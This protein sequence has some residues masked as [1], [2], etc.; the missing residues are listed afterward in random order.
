MALMHN[1]YNKCDKCK[2]TGAESVQRRGKEDFT[3][4]ILCVS[5]SVEKGSEALRF[6]F[7]N[8]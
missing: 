7:P 5:K 2:K 8:F 4:E 6:E 3:I 1:V